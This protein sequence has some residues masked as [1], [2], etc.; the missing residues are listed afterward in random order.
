MFTSREK[1]QCIV[2]LCNNFNFRYQYLLLHIMTL[3]FMY[4]YMRAVCASEASH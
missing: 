2:K 3:N 1:Y 4:S